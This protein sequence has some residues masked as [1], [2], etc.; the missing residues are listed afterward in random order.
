MSTGAQIEVDYRKQTS[1]LRNTAFHSLHHSVRHG[2]SD[3]KVRSL[4]AIGSGNSIAKKTSSNVCI[5]LESN[6]TEHTN[7][8]LSL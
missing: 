7:A 1:I 3:L 4:S 5:S 2:C 6:N 8:E